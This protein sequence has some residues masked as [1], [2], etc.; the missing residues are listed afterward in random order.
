MTE[1]QT[2]FFAT[3]RAAAGFLCDDTGY[4]EGADTSGHAIGVKGTALQNGNG[5]GVQSHGAGDS[6]G[7]AGFGGSNAGIGVFAQGDANGGPAI[8]AQNFPN[9]PVIGV[10]QAATGVEGTSTSGNGVFGSSQTGRRVV[11]IEREA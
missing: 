10:A 8:V 1:T 7:V 5:D 2:E 9:A 4:N 6:S 3:G 11:G